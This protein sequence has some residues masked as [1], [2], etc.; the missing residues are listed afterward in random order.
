MTFDPTI[1]F[2]KLFIPIQICFILLFK[3]LVYQ[4]RKDMFLKKYA[5]L[6]EREI[7]HTNRL[8]VIP[9][10]KHLCRLF[11]EDLFQFDFTKLTCHSILFI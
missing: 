5:A 1:E 4:V 10:L 9:D 3:P 11:A 7:V 2:S 8:F 6:I